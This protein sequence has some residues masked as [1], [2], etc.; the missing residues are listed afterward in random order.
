MSSWKLVKVPAIITLAV[1]L[2]RLVGELAGA[3]DFLF[4]TEPGGGGSPIGITW[5]V[6]IFGFYFGW[7]LGRDGRAPEVPGRVMITYLV[8]IVVV[9]LLFI[10]L[11][12]EPR[13]GE[14]VSTTGIMI[15]MAAGWIFSLVTLFSWSGLTR[16]LFV[17]GLAARIPVIM[18]TLLAVAFGWG[19]H[20]VKLAPGSPE[21]EGAELALYASLPQIGFWIPFTVLVGGLFGCLGG[22]SGRRG[23][24]SE[25]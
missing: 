14:P 8:G 15:T 4:S 3:S 22:L 7:R 11:V 10:T 6:L 25:S 2:I 16:A 23:A 5:L 12:G 18:I 21:M 1:S 9:A 24:A 13:E 19:T 20:H 17:Y